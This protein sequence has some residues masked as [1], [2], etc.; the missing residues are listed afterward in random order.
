MFTYATFCYLRFASKIA[1]R[2]F[3]TKM[4]AIKCAVVTSAFA[5][6]VAEI[7]NSLAERS[8]N[9]VGPQSCRL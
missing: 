4:A 8:L 3:S 1:Q 7:R 2:R 9:T 6:F 5:A